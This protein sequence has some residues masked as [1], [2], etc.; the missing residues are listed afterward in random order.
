MKPLDSPEFMPIYET[1]S[2]HHLP[3]WIHPIGMGG[4]P[5]IAAREREVHPPLCFR[6]AG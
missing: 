1:M 2:K 6:L 3:I 5:F 4:V